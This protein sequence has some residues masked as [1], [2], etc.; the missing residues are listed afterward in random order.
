MA[1][2]LVLFRYLVVHPGM[3]DGRQRVHADDEVVHEHLDH[4][5]D[6]VRAPAASEDAG[7]LT[8]LRAQLNGFQLQYG[9]R[10]ACSCRQTQTTNDGLMQCKPDGT[11]RL[12]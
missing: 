4:R 10:R 2:V 1:R 8:V 12:E 11:R 9:A 7:E 5:G 3:L 6:D